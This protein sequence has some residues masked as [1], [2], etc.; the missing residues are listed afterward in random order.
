MDPISAFLIQ[1]LSL[2]A[3]VGCLC[4][5]VATIHHLLV[6]APQEREHNHTVA[7]E[8]IRLVNFLFAKV[9]DIR[10][11][12]AYRTPAAADALGETTRKAGLFKP[13]LKHRRTIPLHFSAR[14]RP[15]PSGC[16]QR[17]SPTSVGLDL[18]PVCFAA[19]VE[20]KVK[21]QDMVL[22]Q[23]LVERKFWQRWNTAQSLQILKDVHSELCR[24]FALGLLTATA[25]VTPQ[26]W[27]RRYFLFPV[28]Q[29]E[30]A[31]RITTAAGHGTHDCEIA[32]LHCDSLTQAS[33]PLDWQHAAAPL[34]RKIAVKNHEQTKDFA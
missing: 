28:V 25:E 26:V 4:S 20:S 11:R 13:Q 17:Q 19:Y 23:A 7:A 2:G 10:Q 30:L 14:M 32:A 22:R 8:L 1:E 16:V 29:L 6:K 9:R 3:A 5:T 33:I 21:E 15:L 18:Y 24:A 31:L 12:A 34:R 27:R